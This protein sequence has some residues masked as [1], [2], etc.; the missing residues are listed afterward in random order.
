[1]ASVWFCIEFSYIVI[2]HVGFWVLVRFRIHFRFRVS[3]RCSVP[4]RLRV[5]VFE[6]WLGLGFSLFSVLG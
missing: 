5:L 2:F 4:V 6:L 1:M 3:F